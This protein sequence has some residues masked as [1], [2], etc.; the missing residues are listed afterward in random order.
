MECIEQIQT[1]V[2]IVF[3]IFH[4][5]PVLILWNFPNPQY[6]LGELY[7]KRVLLIFSSLQFDA[8]IKLKS[9]SSGAIFH[10]TQKGGRPNKTWNHKDELLGFKQL[11][12]IF[13]AL[14]YFATQKIW[15]NTKKPDFNLWMSWIV[16]WS[17]SS[18]SSCLNVTF[19]TRFEWGKECKKNQ[20]SQGEREAQQKK[21]LDLHGKFSNFRTLFHSWN[22]EKPRFRIAF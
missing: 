3:S 8:Y 12:Y 13:F 18:F 9:F 15:S 21:T 5:F 17:V 10:A 4:V 7:F 22:P 1:F 14:L 19:S 11:F 6:L 16:Y 2:K 20:H